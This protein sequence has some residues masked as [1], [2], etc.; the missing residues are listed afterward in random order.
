[1]EGFPRK[2]LQRKTQSQ[3]GAR[4]YI[5]G[6]ALE[7]IRNGFSGE[8]RT[9]IVERHAPKDSQRFFELQDYPL[10]APAIYRD[11]DPWNFSSQILARIPEE[12]IVLEAPDIRWSDWGTRE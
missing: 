4:I 12:L 6:R 11:I 8:T 10:E 7:H 1:L 5:P 3:N 2:S 9:G